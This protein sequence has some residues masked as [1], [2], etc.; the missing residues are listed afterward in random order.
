MYAAQFL[1]DK[2]ESD[3]AVE[4]EKSSGFTSPPFRFQLR[5]LILLF[6]VKS[7]DGGFLST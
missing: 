6:H 4:N 3:H 1:L 5:E 2:E 7:T